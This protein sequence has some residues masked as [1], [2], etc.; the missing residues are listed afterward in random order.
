MHELKSAKRGHDKFM[1]STTISPDSQSAIQPVLAALG[2]QP[3]GQ[4]LTALAAVLQ[5][6]Q[7]ISEK[8]FPGPVT[9]EHSAD[10]EGEGCDY[11]VFDVAAAGEFADYRDRM[12]Q[13]HDE[14]DR[15][16]PDRRG[17]FRLIVHPQQ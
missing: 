16:A 5:N 7:D 13:W 17:E 14:V 10:P 2:D 9:Y 12:I 11:F 15:I 3:S 6:I 8:L 4:K 1:A